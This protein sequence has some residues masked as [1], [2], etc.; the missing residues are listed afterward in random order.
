MSGKESLFSRLPPRR[1][2]PQRSH[3]K[4]A[5]SDSRVV[6]RIGAPMGQARRGRRYS[7]VIDWLGRR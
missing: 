7:A 1:R 3:R 2:D 5:R 4:P 6:A